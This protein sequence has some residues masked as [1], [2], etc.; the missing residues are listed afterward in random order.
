M[1]LAVPVLMGHNGACMTGANRIRLGFGT[2][3]VI[4]LGL[5]ATVALRNYASQE[6]ARWIASTDDIIH[7][8][9]AISHFSV[10]G[11]NAA[12]RYV[13]TGDVASLAV[14][15]SSTRSALESARKIESTLSGIP[16]ISTT[17]ADVLR[18][19]YQEQDAFSPRDSDRESIRRHLE[20]LDAAGGAANIQTA[21]AAIETYQRRLVI[22]RTAAQPERIATGRIYLGFGLIISASLLAFAGWR[23]VE[24]FTT[25]SIAEQKLAARDEQYRQVV[26]LAGDIIYRTDAA[27]RFTFCNQA[28]L[29][30]LHYTA[31]EVIGRSYLKLIRQDRR[32]AA[33]RF[34][35]R[36]FARNQKSTYYEFP[37]LD[38]HGHEHWIGQNVQPIMEHGNFCGFQSIAREITE[39]KHA[40][41]ELQRSR[42]F[43]ERI[44]ATT[45]GVLYVYEIEEKRTVFS[46]RAVVTVL[47]YK[48]EE[49]MS[50]GRGLHSLI[51]PDDQPLIN[52]HY[53][54]MRNV[55][56][57]EIR[58][59]EYRIR[60]ADGR[61]VWL[62][63]RETAFERS[64]DGRVRQV[65]GI[66]QDITARKAAQ[67]TLAYQANYDALTGL[68]NR[69][70]FWTRLQTSLRR[71]RMDHT[72]TSLCLFDVDN[73]KE[74]NDRYGHAAGDEVLEEIGNIVRDEIRSTDISGRLG[75]DEFCF[76]LPGTDHDEAARVADRMRNRLSTLAFGIQSG[77]PFSVT[78]TFGVAASIPDMDAKELME[79]ADRALY[80][81]KAAGRNRVCV[82]V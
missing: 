19:I 13:A 3:L 6:D 80:R 57:G 74:I 36:Q 9:F 1:G 8:I 68:P 10:L 14:A 2:G 58:R 63:S 76:V 34:Y 7:D 11:E 5:A 44:A 23:M 39:R 67:E 29:T 17:F 51:H 31:A 62:A 46:N 77:S 4:L 64:P 37:V 79:A 21:L 32:R 53:E 65:I 49:I 61:W 42:N 48:P 24:D 15:R 59:L 22:E 72:R 26:D 27:G 70:H 30:M 20:K 40:E 28:A 12:R 60:H 33:V 47:G 78:A 16:G 54:A 41:L 18:Q 55:Q 45:P 43:I 50:P 82:D 25:R 52:S 75:G 35:L 69:H 73:F 38:G 56:D 71:S 81:A 66:S